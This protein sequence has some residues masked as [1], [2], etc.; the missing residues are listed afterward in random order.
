M[1]TILL[2]FCAMLLFGDFLTTTLAL[3]LANTN[4]DQSGAYVSEANPLMATI[5]NTPVVFLCVKIFI[6]LTVVAAAYILRNEGAIA[7]LPC[8]LVCGFYII[9]N[10]NNIVILVNH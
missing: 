3:S 2:T 1:H 9:V 4:H 5:V 10:M 6:L 8:I 7:Y